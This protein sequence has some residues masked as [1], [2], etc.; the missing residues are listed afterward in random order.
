MLKR[1][2]RK[3]GFTLVEVMIVM[4]LIAISAVVVYG[5]IITV[6]CRGNFWFSEE[7]VLRELKV[8]HPGVTEIL[9]TERNVHAKSVITVKEDGFNHVYYLDSDMLW[10][11][12][13]SESK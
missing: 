10:N 5:F 6:I 9:K 7:G 12:K 4:G 1:L 2:R 8:D 13:F 3:N 11:Y